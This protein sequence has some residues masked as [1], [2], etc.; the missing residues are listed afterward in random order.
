M[1]TTD[2]MASES[3]V[4]QLARAWRP[5]RKLR[6]KDFVSLLRCG[7]RYSPL[8][9]SDLAKVPVSDGDRILDFHFVPNR[10]NLYRF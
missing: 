6:R 5:V 9:P 1:Q 3:A 7:T 10:R 4:N 2:S 8:F